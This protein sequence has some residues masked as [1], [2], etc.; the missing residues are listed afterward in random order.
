MPNPSKVP[1]HR[2]ALSD[3]TSAVICLLDDEPA[4]LKGIGRLLASEGL[5]VRQFC[6]PDEFLSFAKTHRPP[7]AIIDIWMPKM[8]GLE[9]QSRLKVISPSTRVIVFT[10]KD[11]PLIRTT[12]LEAGAAAF[13]IKPFDDVEFLT[14]SRMALAAIP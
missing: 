4:V 2:I 9:V 5:N 1:Q 12:A 14:A 10:G 13:F 8:N 11:D 6:D 3:S 7:L